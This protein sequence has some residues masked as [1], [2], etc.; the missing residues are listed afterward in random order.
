MEMEKIV[1]EALSKKELM[2]YCLAF[3]NSSYTQQRLVT[4]H[5]PTPKGSYTITES[6]LKEIPI[7]NPTDKKAVRTILSYS[8]KRNLGSTD[9]DE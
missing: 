6:F 3:M 2:H 1:G 7:P 5:R 8:A 9:F 4:G